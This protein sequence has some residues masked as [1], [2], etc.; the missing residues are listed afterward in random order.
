MNLKN[1]KLIF[2]I[3]KAISYTAVSA[4]PQAVKLTPWFP[5]LWKFQLAFHVEMYINTFLYIFW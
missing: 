1:N 5:S 4:C 3:K 2:I